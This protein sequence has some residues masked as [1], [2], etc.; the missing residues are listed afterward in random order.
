MAYYYVNRNPQPNGE[1]EVHKSGCKHMPNEQ[2]RIFLG[3]FYTCFEA[4]R[5]AQ[6][7][8]PNTNGCYYCCSEC[9]SG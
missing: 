2:N 1:H 6:K 4:V 8:Y 9:H 7:I 3:D 5:T